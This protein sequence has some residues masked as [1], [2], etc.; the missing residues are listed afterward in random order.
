[1]NLELLIHAQNYIEKMANGINPL[2]GKKV[3][4]NETIN[5]IRISRCL[6]YVN[7][8]LKNIILDSN[9]Q[10][11]KSSFNL[12][13]EEL[14]NYDYFN[15]S[16]SISKNVKKLNNLKTN[17]YMENL[18]VTQICNWLISV[19]LL[20]IKEESGSKL[21]RPTIEGEKLG[22]YLEHVIKNNRE[23]DIVLYNR[24]AQ[25][26]IIDNFSSMIDFIKNNQ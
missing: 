22:M 7:D 11:N 2:T 20:Y 21:K 17:K 3:P 10:I 9:F 19:N 12:T 24:E 8:V 5:N 1:M 26:F 13:K 15:D 16:I 14:N 6:F 18:K 23:Y 25:Q 4:Q